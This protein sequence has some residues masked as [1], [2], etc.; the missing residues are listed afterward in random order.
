MSAI[1]NWPFCIFL[2]N[3]ISNSLLAAKTPGYE[4]L[5]YRTDIKVRASKHMD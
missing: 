2:E 1:L 4:V 3:L 5:N